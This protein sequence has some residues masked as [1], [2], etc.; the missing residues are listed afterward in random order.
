MTSSTSL[1]KRLVTLH[2]QADAASYLDG[3]L[4][5]IAMRKPALQA[6]MLCPAMQR[7]FLRLSYFV[8]D[9]PVRE[10]TSKPVLDA[11]LE[12]GLVAFFHCAD[13][14]RDGAAH[15]LQAAL[16]QLSDLLSMQVRSGPY[17]WDAWGDTPLGDWLATHG[18]YE[19]RHR[20]GPAEPV[21]R[22]FKAHVLDRVAPP[23]ELSALVADPEFILQAPR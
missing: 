1:A 20:S 11:A 8:T 19:L 6:Q 14:R 2:E 3:A 16:T 4:R 17:S 21:F 7:V 9:A 22:A 15:F 23:V 18:H 10:M 12:A 13:P 5:R